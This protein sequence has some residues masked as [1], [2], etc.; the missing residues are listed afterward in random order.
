VSSRRS[1]PVFHPSTQ[2]M[3]V[4]LK[5]RNTYVV[6]FSCHQLSAALHKLCPVCITLVVHHSPVRVALRCHSLALLR[7]L[8]QWFP[9]RGLSCSPSLCRRPVV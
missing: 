4:F 8:G 6:V 9:D 7:S 5:G 3:Y 1:V 2:Y